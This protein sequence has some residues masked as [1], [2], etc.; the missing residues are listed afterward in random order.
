MN[1]FLAILTCLAAPDVTKVVDGPTVVVTQPDESKFPEI[2]VYYE[3]KRADQSFILDARRDEFRA[4][5]DG[6]DRPILRFQA[7]ES[8][9]A[10]PT[11]VVLV[12][13]RSES[14]REGGRIGALKRAVSTF[15]EGLPAGS[16]V[17]VIAFSSEI[18][19]VCPFTTD[20][21]K[22]REAVDALEPGGATRYYEAVE[23]ALELLAKEPGRR[24]VLAL[25]DGEDNFSWS[26]VKLI[27]SARNISELPIEGKNLVVVALVRKVLHF[28]VFDFAGSMIVDT[29]ER[30]VAGRSRETDN[31]LAQLRGNLG[32]LWPPHA[33][34]GDEKNWLC[35]IAS[36]IA[37]H[38]LKTPED[39]FERVAGKARRAGLPVHTLGFGNEDE[40]AV[41][42][43]AKLA[44]D[45]RGQHYLARDAA[46]LRKIYEE[47]AQRLGSSYSLTYQTD[48]KV[49]DGTLRPIRIYYQKAVRAGETAVFIRGMVV[50]ANGWSGLFLALLVSLV[51]LARL[52]HGKGS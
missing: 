34:D 47:I 50:P 29:D 4:T 28:R 38:E 8:T 30:K 35:T 5:E 48:R 2:T 32:S 16:R 24:A 31:L 7:P 12:V 51:V 43:L 13:D 19:L 46:S 37:G 21:A 14:M 41:G 36:L 33:L 11:T 3:V 42:A 39:A 17:A 15:L 18:K 6:Q 9:E 10:R 52:P 45:T 40:I 25:T 20:P 27:P 49:P 23:A 26:E 1:I 44:R 22:V